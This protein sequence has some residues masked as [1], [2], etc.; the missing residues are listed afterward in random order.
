MF[1]AGD[2]RTTVIHMSD[3]DVVHA[4]FDAYR[5][6]DA[7]AAEALFAPHFRFTSPQDDHID[8]AAFME[9]CFPT[10]HLFTDSDFL[11]LIET[12]HGVLCLYENEHTD[13]TRFRNV[14]LIRVE[15]DLI[16]ETQVFFG[17]QVG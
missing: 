9:R 4:S 6:Q 1:P 12:P 2:I 8:R 11:E 13:G 15:N 5:R 17:G 16:V 10:A 7:A 3:T 14:E